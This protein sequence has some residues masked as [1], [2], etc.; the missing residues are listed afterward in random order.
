M[1]INVYVERSA[2]RP[3][4]NA[5]VAEDR[6]VLML[7]PYDGKNPARYQTLFEKPAD[8]SG[9]LLRRWSSSGQFLRGAGGIALALLAACEPQPPSCAAALMFPCNSV[10]LDKE[11][12]S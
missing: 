5:L 4:P 10:A 2:L 11:P 7:F 8:A 9:P 3:W 1:A 12:T 6:I